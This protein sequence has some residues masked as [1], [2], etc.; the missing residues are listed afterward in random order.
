[1]TATARLKQL[2]FIG[3]ALALVALGLVAAVSTASPARATGTVPC[4]PSGPQD[5]TSGWLESPPDGRAWQVS[6]TRTKEGTGTPATTERINYAWTGGDTATAPAVDSL[7]WQPNQGNHNGV[8]HQQPDNT[9]YQVGNG[10]NGDNAS[11]FIWK[12]ITTPGIP[13]VFE[14]IY[15]LH[16]DA[17]ICPGPGPEVCPEGQTGTPPN[18]VTPPAE[19]KIVVCK[20][21]GTPP[22]GLSHVIVVSENTL[23]N[24]KDEEGNSFTGVFPF[25]WTDAQ[26]QAGGSIAIG[27]DDGSEPALSDCPYV[28]TP[29]EVCPEGQTGTPPNCETPPEVCPEGQTGTPPNCET[30]PEV[31][32][33]GQVGTPPNCTPAPGPDCEADPHAEG[34]P[35]DDEVC[36]PG[37]DH[38]GQEVKHGEDPAKVCND[39]DNN[40]DNPGEPN[41]PSNHPNPGPTVKGAQATAPSGSPSTPTV[42]AAPA[43]ARVPSAI[44]AGLAPS[45]RDLTDHGGSLGLLGIAGALLGA[46]LVGASLRPRRRRSLTV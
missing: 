2:L 14:H 21:T 22:G 16:I 15:T 30:P 39:E 3:A 25:E 13:A 10:N 33:E 18:C 35:D 45:H 31:C 4:V 7:F 9:P 40:P 23:N 29:P 20:Y 6:D 8:P 28:E 41:G 46:G 11:W 38:A 44:D 32:P 43:A 36:P 5:L 1:M 34:C 17:V 37:T 12:S 19:K 42:A 24:V 27:Y 26:G